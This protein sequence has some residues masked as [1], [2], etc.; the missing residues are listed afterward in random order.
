MAIIVPTTRGTLTI[1]L[2]S[3]EIDPNFEDYLSETHGI[4]GCHNPGYRKDSLSSLE[5]KTYK[6]DPQ[7]RRFLPLALQD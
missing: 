5:E 1:S 4:K 3:G 2:A 7:E 6:N